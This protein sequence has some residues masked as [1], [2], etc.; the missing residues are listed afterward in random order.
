[1]IRV[2]NNELFLASQELITILVSTASTC[3]WIFPY[4]GGIHLQ[5]IIPTNIQLTIMELVDT[6]AYRLMCIFFKK[7]TLYVDLPTDWLASLRQIWGFSTKQNTF[8]ISTTSPTPSPSTVMA[9]ALII[10]VPFIRL[11]LIYNIIKGLF[12]SIFVDCFYGSISRYDRFLF[13]FAHFTN[14]DT[15]A[16]F[17]YSSLEWNWPSVLRFLLTSKF[18]STCVPLAK[19]DD[20]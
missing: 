2:R 8:I 1:M 19:G 15:I 14:L 18:L 7:K 10:V 6:T 17:Y 3:A 12:T 11:H 16:Y 4:S 13:R 9:E 5:S 20:D